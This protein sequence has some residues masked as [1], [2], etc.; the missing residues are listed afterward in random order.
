MDHLSAQVAF[1]PRV[2]GT[3]G[4]DRVRAWLR[5]ELDRTAAR[6]EE[7]RFRG[8]NGLTGGTFEGINF[9]A[10]FRPELAERIFLGAHWDTRAWADLDP[11]P[12]KRMDPVPGA[13]D[14]ASGVA[15][16][17]VL[18]EAMKRN[19]PPIGVDLL[20]FDGEDQGASGSASGFCLGA[21][22]FA[23]SA[24]LT[25]FAPRWGVVVDMVGHRRLRIAR[26]RHSV[27]CCADLAARIEA[28]GRR[29]APEIFQP[30][31]IV[32]LYDDH[33]PFIEAGI[34]AVL[35][36]GYGFPE[37]HTT[38]DLPAICSEESLAAVGA[39]L[40]ELIYGG[41]EMP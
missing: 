13:S 38:S 36:A 27:D 5:E 17:L 33:V 40:L 16:L 12:A 41:H 19:P 24:S 34:P 2:P 1:G 35:L 11:D 37:W 15:V 22:S 20:F 7:R 31:S 6:V 3:I 4:H 8:E 25:G 10:S 21:R 30:S 39:V 29:L 28:I 26:E 18:A 32:Y 14:G 9:R 23:A